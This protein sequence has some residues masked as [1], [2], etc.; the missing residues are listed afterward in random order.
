M[1]ER[2]ART[3]LVTGAT[4]LLGKG[5]EETMPAGWRMLG[6]HQRPYKVTSRLAVHRALDIRDRRAVERLFAARKFDAVVH[7][8]GIASVDYVESHYAESLESNIVGTLNVTSAC[9]RSGTP[10]VYV[11]TNAVFDGTRAPYSEDA[12]VNPVNKYGR[13]KVECERL[14]RETLERWTVVRP[15]LMYGW[16]R[17]ETRPNTV[18]WI[19]DK[20][21]KGEPVELVDDVRENPLYSLQCGR[22]LWAAV[23][24]MPG[25]TIHLAGKDA[26]SRHEFGLKIADAF[27]LDRSL[28]RRVDSSRFPS[29]APRP[30]DTTMLTVRMER[31]LGVAPMTLEEGLRSMREA[32]AKE[33]R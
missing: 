28:V 6:V 32:R 18:T 5:M 14:V 15:I 20:L 3:V 11:S 10:L 30:P 22:A 31:E 29:I 13:L 4:G 19:L 16:N 26:A 7:A 9:R 17:P 24:R 8:A 25:G 23:E 21:S 33:K 2:K 12:P 27:G 1:A